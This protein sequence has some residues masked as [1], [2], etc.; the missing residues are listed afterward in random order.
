MLCFAAAQVDLSI[1]P[2]FD[3]DEKGPGAEGWWVVVEDQDCEIILHSEF[4][5]IRRSQSDQHTVLAFTVPISEPLPPQYFVKVISDTWLGCESSI[6]LDFRNLILPERFP[7]SSELLDLQ[8]L[9][10]SALR[11]P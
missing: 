6:A 1:T 8:P 2:D 3:W 5:V 4:T 7:P 11:Q 9:P 10:I